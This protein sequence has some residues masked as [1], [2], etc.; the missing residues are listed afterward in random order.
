MARDNPD[1]VRSTMSFRFLSPLAFVLCLGLALAGCGA[2]SDEPS[3]PHETQL[4]APLID[5]PAQA[6]AGTRGLV[7]SVAAP[8]ADLDYTW[9][10]EGG[11]IESA[12]A[13][14]SIVFAVG[15][16]PTASLTV[17]ASDAKGR[18][19]ST[20][21]AIEILPQQEVTITAP[22]RVTAGSEGIVATV[23]AM[24][25]ASYAWSIEGG[26]IRAG[27]GTASIAFDVTDPHAV[28]LAV[29]IVD[30]AG[31]PSHGAKT[32]AVVA[33]ADATIDAPATI[34]A[35]KAGYTASVPAQLETSF[36]WSI[37]NG[38][39]TSGSETAGVTFT[40]TEPG[41]VLLAVEVT[42]AAGDTVRGE[43]HLLAAPPP[44]AT[45]DLEYGPFSEETG[46]LVATVPA[47]EG[48]TYDWQVEGG[49]IEEGQGTRRLTFSTGSPGTLTITATVT[50]AAGDVTSSSVTRTVV[51]R[52]VAAIAAPTIAT[53]GAEGLQATAPDQEGV[54]YV[55][56]IQGG[57]ITAGA[58]TPTVT[59][60]AGDGEALVLTVMVIN[61]AADS[62]VE[63]AVIVLVP[64]PVATIAAPA[65]PVTA[66]DGGLQASVPAQPGASY[67]W[68]VTNGSIVAGQGTETIVFQAGTPGAVELAVQVTNAAG[69]EVHGTHTLEAVPPPSAAIAVYSTIV[70]ENASGYAASVQAQ[71]GSTYLW[72]IVNGTITAG[73]GTERIEFETGA[74]GAMELAVTVTNAAGRSASESL[75]LEAVPAPVPTI[76]APTIV[77]SGTSDLVASV[78]WQT[79]STFTWSI[80]NGT[81]T[82]G[83]GTHEIRF[84]AGG[85][86]PLV[87]MATVANAA[88]DSAIGTR[89]VDVVPAPDATITLREGP[90]GEYQEYVASVPDQP[91]A[92]YVWSVTG[93][94]IESGHAS[95]S[96]TV[97][98]GAPGELQLSVTVINAASDMASSSVSR[99]VIPSPVAEIVFARDYL[100]ENTMYLAWAQEQSGAT[101]RW[102][103]SGGTILGAG[104]LA[105]IQFQ[106]GSAGP[107]VLTLEVENAAGVTAIATRTV[108]VIGPPDTTILVPSGPFTAGRQ[109]VA[110]AVEQPG[111]SYEWTVTNGVLRSG[112]G[113]SSIEF[114][115]SVSSV[116]LTLRVTNALGASAT[117][118]TVLPVISAPYAFINAP[119]KV[120]RGQENLTASVNQQPN[121]TYA[122]SISGG[123]ITSAIDGSSITFKAGYGN[124]VALSV[125]VTNAAGDSATGSKAVPAVWGISSNV[126][127]MTTPRSRAR[128]VTLADG[129]VLVAGGYS[130]YNTVESSSEIFSSATNSFTATGS[131]NARRADH[132][133]TLLEDG[134]VLV[135]GGYQ[136]SSALA[137]AEIYD[138]A[139]GTW[140]PTTPMANARYAHSATRLA[141]GRVLVAGGMTT[142][143]YFVTSAEIFDP[144][145]EL[146]S[147][148]GDL[149]PRYE[150]TA[151]LLDDGRVLVAGNSSWVQ[152]QDAKL[153]DPVTSTWSSAGGGASLPWN[154][155]A[156]AL[157]DGRLLLSGGALPSGNKVANQVKARLYDPATNQYTLVADMPASRNRHAS[158]VLPS[159]M[160]LIAGGFNIV[161]HEYYYD[162]QGTVAVSL[163]DPVNN[164]WYAGENLL[165]P[166]TYEATALLPDG[167]VLI[168]GGSLGEPVYGVFRSAEIYTPA[169]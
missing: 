50:N 159:G 121:S 110:Q 168:A 116:T 52:P 152:Y 124:S 155:S 14:P 63:D 132:T 165:T 151:T 160:V 77:S 158:Y 86:G 65:G 79:R 22:D 24:D 101:Y 82:S 111:A 67:T 164:L 94:T 93:G 37:T 8:L 35:G 43:A 139:T 143:L 120:L 34:T 29:R 117:G 69:D 41:E 13:G 102:T 31:V 91:G 40:A 48:A 46:D 28:H 126:G 90:L 23:A 4:P 92:G 42:N 96:I 129:R 98:T 9:E 162:N 49:T 32:I 26:S 145:T 138:P 108:H 147:P 12:S 36:R 123:T 112:Q 99:V 88:G 113:T 64:P 39:I 144:V 153:F 167:R 104:D 27:E 59:F 85:P 55:W 53:R 80:S 57:T 81:I 25:G 68:A 75:T 106:S 95:P 105:W 130:S 97:R 71:P 73:Q 135:T 11:S 6:V 47:Q 133:M 125:T 72:S 19:A 169:R 115:P 83:Q 137:S 76:T 107:L 127:D 44:D 109:Y 70:T 51:A 33:P 149:G 154:L 148:A 61:E 100:A 131:M 163:Y 156:V 7:A 60:T 45:I 2:D 84:E 62:A 114:S 136:P 17:V 166:R 10:I 157:E 119:A 18:T 54:T 3:T 56:S 87:L 1:E 74:A 15:E 103:I 141:D 16:G 150:H 161:T 89:T 142:G 20:T 122:W 118:S 58:D 128:A 30:A 21:H 78:P 140:T 5:A 134:R 66:G 38:T 146:W